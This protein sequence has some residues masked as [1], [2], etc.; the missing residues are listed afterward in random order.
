MIG[1]SGAQPLA[2]FRGLQRGAP[3]LSAIRA[4]SCLDKP[5]SSS[6]LGSPLTDLNAAVEAIDELL[7]RHNWRLTFAQCFHYL[8]TQVQMRL[9]E[10]R[11][12]QSHP[13]I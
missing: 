2:D 9:D 3:S 6:F 13:L 5:A 11:R 10:L 1:R 7:G 4:C 12:S 8:W